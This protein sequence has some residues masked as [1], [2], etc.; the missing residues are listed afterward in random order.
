MA[1]AAS[2]AGG[3]GGMSGAGSPTR[4]PISESPWDTMVSTPLPQMMVSSPFSIVVPR[5]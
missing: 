5:G 4:V 1:A 3:R 2:R